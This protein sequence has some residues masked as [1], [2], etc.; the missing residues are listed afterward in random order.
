MELVEEFYNSSKEDEK[1]EL[2][3][4]VQNKKNSYINELMEMA[5]K[6]NF[7]VKVTNKGFAFIPLING[8]VISEREYDNLDKENPFK[9]LTVF[10]V[11]NIGFRRI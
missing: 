1:D 2:I 8:K 4:E 3:E 5:K 7:E 6:E 9:Y 10:E 11:D